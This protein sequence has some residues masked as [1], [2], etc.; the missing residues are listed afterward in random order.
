MEHSASIF[1]GLGRYVA[2]DTLHGSCGNDHT[3]NAVVHVQFHPSVAF[4]GE[5]GSVDDTVYDEVG[6]IVD[7]TAFLA[8]HPHGR[9]TGYGGCRAQF[10]S[11]LD[12]ELRCRIGHSAKV[13]F[14]LILI[15]ERAY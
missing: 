2:V 10:G 5:F 6:R 3:V 9:A 8:F 13:A 11:V 4:L 15:G 12:D 7:D 1:Y 14:G